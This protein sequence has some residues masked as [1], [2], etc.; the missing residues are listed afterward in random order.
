MSEAPP[1][2]RPEGLAPPVAERARLAYPIPEAAAVLGIGRT[3]LYKLVEEGAI[4]T[5]TIG[6][7]R[8][9]PHSALED[10]LARR[11]SEAA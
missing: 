7:R 3:S 4:H 6:R 10:Y 11:M 5:V 9:V 2:A 1:V 8:V